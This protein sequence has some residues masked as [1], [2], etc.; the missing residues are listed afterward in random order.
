VLNPNEGFSYRL[1][2]PVNRKTMRCRYVALINN[3]RVKDIG[4]PKKP[5][6]N[7][8]QVDMDP[9][10]P[11]QLHDNYGGYDDVEDSVD[12]TDEGNASQD[13]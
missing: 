2:G 9:I 8:P 3:Q 10:N 12:V 1:W 4:K 13:N 7:A 6:I 5:K 11:L